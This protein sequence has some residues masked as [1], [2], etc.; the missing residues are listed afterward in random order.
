[1][2]G[3]QTSRVELSRFNNSWYN[4]GRSMV[5]QGLWFLAGAPLLR[6]RLNPF[7]VLRRWLLRLFG[8]SISRGVV[9]RPGVKVKYPWRLHIGEYAWIGEDVWIDNLGQVTIGPNTCLSQGAYLCTGNHNW[10]DPRFGLIVKGIRIEEG[11]WVGA[12]SIIC[13]GVQVGKNAIATA[14]SVVTKSIPPAQIH[15]GNPARF[16]RNRILNVSTDE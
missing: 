15:T 10:S 9:I 14:G 13:P 7:S 11:A 8:A 1:M 5:V 3:R 4:P 2:L 16:V 6:C 12:K